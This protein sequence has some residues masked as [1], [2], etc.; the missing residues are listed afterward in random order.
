MARFAF[1]LVFIL[2]GCAPE[3][4]KLDTKIK[5]KLPKSRQ[6]SGLRHYRPQSNFNANTISNLNDVD[7]YAIV[8]GF[9]ANQGQCEQSGGTVIHSAELAFGSYPDGAEIELFIPSGPAR[10]FYLYGFS[11]SSA[12]CP[13]FINFPIV[14]QQNSSK[15]VLLGQTTVSVEGE[16]M[17]VD[18]TRS[19]ANAP[20]AYQ[21]L[22]G[23]F[24]WEGVG[25]GAEGV[26]GLGKWDV[27]VWGP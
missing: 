15:P 13:D 27:A 8:V 20:I 19:L 11:N 17:E 1:L 4:E 25:A 21:C 5:F 6:Q 22:D 3:A 2:V 7:C 16:F 9:G 23:P 14:D 24:A 10:T 18:I 26:W 12:S